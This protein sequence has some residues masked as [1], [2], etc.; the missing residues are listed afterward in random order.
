MPPRLEEPDPATVLMVCGPNPLSTGGDDR[1]RAPA[2]IAQ[3]VWFLGRAS[4]SMPPFTTR[5]TGVTLFIETRYLRFLPVVPIAS[6]TRITPR[7]R[8]NKPP[9]WAADVNLL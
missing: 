4:R 6:A 2:Q 8:R 7:Y 5:E 3:L 9:S 1:G